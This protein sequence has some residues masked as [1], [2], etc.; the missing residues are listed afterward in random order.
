MFARTVAVTLSRSVVAAGALLGACALASPKVVLVGR[1]DCKD[2]DLVTSLRLLS[3]SLEARLGPSLV[4]EGSVRGRIAPVPASSPKDIELQLH[5][6]K[7][8][9]YDGRYTSALRQLEAALEQVRLIP[10]A[11]SRFK[12][13]AELLVYKGNTLRHEGRLKEATEA[14]SQIVRVNPSYQLDPGQFAP[15]TREFF[16]A[17]RAQVL[18][19][20]RYELK[21][22]SEPSGAAAYLEGFPIGKTP[23]AASLPA[24]TYE[25]RV[26]REGTLSFPHEVTLSQAQP[27]DVDLGFEGGITSQWPACTRRSD[28]ASVGDGLKLGALLGAD[29]VVLARLER[30]DMGPLWLIATLVHVASAQSVREGRIK[31]PEGS[32][33]PPGIDDLVHFVLTGQVSTAV[34]SL[35]TPPQPTPPPSVAKAAVNAAVK[36]PAPAALAPPSRA[37]QVSQSSGA[38]LDHHRIELG[39]AVT[40]GAL[41][42]AG[43]GFELG[44]QA[45][46][47][48]FKGYFSGAGPTPA[49]AGQV[50][51]LW[52]DAQTFQTVAMV[53]FVTAGAVAAADGTLY[54]FDRRHARAE[55]TVTPW[56]GAGSTG[57]L[58]SASLP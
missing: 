43:L 13:E 3:H 50:K 25:V 42:L 54:W 24:G 30:K 39:L 20:P 32:S 49:Q 55:V 10:P 12:L 31:V 28:P 14:F 4:D 9:F 11:A 57:A 1:G 58:L 7:S 51:G 41:A 5:N 15:S 52:N 45:K 23:L 8:L 38:V 6:A 17:V 26:A 19:Q 22:G 47:S 21:I 35:A 37:E 36:A 44:A 40:S 16:H 33:A 2:A 18:A 29:D 34:Q 46:Y 27:L 53:S 56:V 48:D